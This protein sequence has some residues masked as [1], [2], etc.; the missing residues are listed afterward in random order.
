MEHL[1]SIDLIL[2]SVKHFF[3]INPQH[4]CSASISLIP[5]DVSLMS[6]L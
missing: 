2:S 5:E 6:A 4:G 3:G 1:L